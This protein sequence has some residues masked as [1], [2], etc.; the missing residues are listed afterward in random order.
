MV[1]DV[2]IR[3]DDLKK[4]LNIDLLGLVEAKS[5]D[6]VGSRIL[7]N[8]NEGLTTDFELQDLSLRID[9]WTRLERVKSIFVLGMS[10]YWPCDFD[11]AYKISSYAR[12]RDYHLVL[13]E[14]IQELKEILKETFEFSSY[15]QVDSGGFYEKE[16]ARLGGFGHYGKNSLII[17][18]DLGSYFFLGLLFTSI[19][20]S[21]FIY[22]AEIDL[23][24]CGS[25]N[26]CKEACPTGAILGDYRVDFSKCLSYLS[27]KKN[28]SPY[29][30]NLTYAYGCD[31][32]QEVCPKNRGILSDVHLDF[33]PKILS[34][35]DLDLASLSN[36][37]FKKK[38][39]DFAFAWSGK[40]V[41][42][43]NIKILASRGWFYVCR[44]FRSPDKNLWGL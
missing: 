28:A 37:A 17:N 44:C 22:K 16:L 35:D 19:P 30:N 8:K 18:K 32:C 5:L 20:A 39:K 14:K 26:L 4:K 6:Q 24:S 11:G 21:K 36:K 29:L 15:I 27:Q 25:C 2:D 9:P 31:V 40:K 42:E 13:R 12:G 34:F 33:K 41:I 3:L 23:S 1:K 38:Y 43:R 10:Y 7:S